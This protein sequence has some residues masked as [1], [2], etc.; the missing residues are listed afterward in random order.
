M[1][2]GLI[3]ETLGHS[4]SEILHS[5]IGLYEYELCPVKKE[6]FDSF[7]KSRD[8]RGINVTI[9]YKSDVISYLDKISPEA[10]KIGAVNTV[11]NRNGKLFGFNTDFAGMKAA[12]EK[13]RIGIQNKNVLILGTGGTSKTALA[14]CTALGAK[15]AVRV[16]RTKKDGSLSYEEALGRSETEVILNTTPVGMHPEIDALPIDLSFFPNLSGVMDVIY[17][18]LKTKLLREAEKRGIPAIGGLF[19]LVAQAGFAAEIFAEKEDLSSMIEPLFDFILKKQENLVLIGMPACGKSTI[20]KELANLL[21]KDFI[22]S[23]EV[24][25]KEEKKSIPAIFAEG[26]EDA[27]RKIE[28]RVIREIAKKGGCVIAV[29]GG[30]ILREE[31]V[32][33]LKQNGRIFFLDAP[34]SDLQST[35]SRPLSSTPEDLKKRYEERY[36]IYCTVCDKKIPITRNLEENLLKIQKELQ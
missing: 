36:G 5:K 14:L 8:F 28:T 26:G 11:V 3:G 29:G 31:N 20:G 23:D 30:A 21:G 32:S 17:N 27:F 35:A 12:L 25:E 9:P 6:E 10:E 1:K 19:M 2:Y 7:M 22:D 18:P 15:S 16:G 4:F 13:G 24:I 33:A 34:L